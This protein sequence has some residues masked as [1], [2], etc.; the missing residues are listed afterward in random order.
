M[1]SWITVEISR[2]SSSFTL[3]MRRVIFK[4]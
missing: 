3:S 1:P 2:R 4:T